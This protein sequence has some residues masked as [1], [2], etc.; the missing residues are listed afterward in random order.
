MVA[1]GIGDRDVGDILLPNPHIR[2][3]RVPP[4]GARLI[5][6]SDG[7]WDTMPAG[8][9]ARV[10]RA[11]GSAKAAATQAVTSVAACRGGLFADDVTGGWG[12]L[13]T[14]GAGG[15]R[16]PA[17]S[18]HPRRPAPCTPAQPPAMRRRACP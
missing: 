6:A 8:R 18:S 13:L 15:S 3:V 7:L 1:R 2:Q 5:L 12:S 17:S 4:S 9:V 16:R 11:H 14:R 10:L